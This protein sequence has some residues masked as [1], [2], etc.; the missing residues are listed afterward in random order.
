MKM[1]YSAL[2]FLSLFFIFS[3]IVI[4]GY[5]LS[6]DVFVNSYFTGT[7]QGVF[8]IY[9]KIL[10]YLY[11]FFAVL[12]TRLLFKFYK[13]GEK[14]ETLLLGITVFFSVF[15]QFF[16]KPIFNV[17]CPGSYYNS[18]FTSYKLV[19]NF[20]FFQKIALGETCYPSNHTI[21]YI[22]ICGYLA[23]L[24]HNY[25][26]KKRETNL[27]IAILIFVILTIGLTRVYL[28]V[29]W[30]SD[31]IAG[32]F[33]GGFYLSIILWLSEHRNKLKRNILR[34]YEKLAKIKTR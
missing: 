3:L 20:E 30:F 5:F 24:M 17:L 11:I 15:S 8:F 21:A 2:V 23:Y 1:F 26:A 27:I 13:K 7:F 29:H 34:I 18:V 25:F 10:D 14:M 28:H 12:C 19:S 16:V 32:Y 31:V 4:S 6:I 22:V 9:S 33:L